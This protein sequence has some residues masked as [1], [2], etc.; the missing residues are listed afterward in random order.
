MSP[1]A[2]QDSDR[3][4]PSWVLLQTYGQMLQCTDSSLGD[5]DMHTSESRALHYA[6]SSLVN[7][8]PPERNTFR[9]KD[10]ACLIHLGLSDS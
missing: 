10:L 8:P 3:N 2:A 5:S 1:S 7:G 4:A 9:G 6:A